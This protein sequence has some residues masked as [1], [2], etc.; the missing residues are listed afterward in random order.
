MWKCESIPPSPVSRLHR[1]VLCLYRRTC[2]AGL[3]LGV[4][5]CRPA[6]RHQSVII[7]GE[8]GAGKSE[9]CKLVLQFI[10]DLSAAHSGRTVTED[11]QSLEQQLLQV[12][13]CGY[14]WLWVCVLFL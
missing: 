2:S 5:L 7:T 1:L 3:N 4:V 6:C 12:G 13:G 14:V 9:A 11:E 10:A 8:S